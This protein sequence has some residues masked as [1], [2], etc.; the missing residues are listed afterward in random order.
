MKFL[1]DYFNSGTVKQ[2]NKKR[3]GAL[4]ICIT[5]ALLAVALIAL[6]IA[7]IATAIKGKAPREEDGEE[8]G[9][10]GIPSGYTT[11]TF[12]QSQL[13]SGTLLLIDETH[14]YTGTPTVVLMNSAR[15]SDDAGEYLYW[16]YDTVNFALTQDALDAFNLMVKDFHAES[17]DNNLYVKDAY[18]QSAATQVTALHQTGT[19]LTLLYYT[20]EGSTDGNP[21]DKK[22]IHNV[23]TYKWLYD[24]AH[25]YGFVQASAVEGEENIFR[26]VG[27]AHATYMKNNNK[28]LAE[29]LDILQTRTA[30]R[31]L[32]VQI[33]TKN[34]EGQAVSVAYNI[35]HLTAEETPIVPSKFSYTVSGDNMGGYIVT[36]DR[37]SATAN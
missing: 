27:V 25:E 33:S 22:T 29:Y 35:Y 1:S 9:G 14:T 4:L 10:S 19:A 30:G 6:M 20:Y 28:T 3:F 23:D 32:S 17:G 26:Y 18:N 12:D 8:T 7:S 34:A 36:V 15:P 37:S 31:P 21:T 11:T 5:A 24:H 13:S 2:Q 16:L